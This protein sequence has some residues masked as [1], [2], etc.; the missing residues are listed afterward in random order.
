MVTAP[1]AWSRRAWD[2]TS[3]RRQPL[4]LWLLGLV[5]V[6]SLLARVAWLGEPCRSPCRSAD[7][8]VL[9]FDEAYYVNAARVID[10]IRP[11]AGQHYADAPLH[12][13]PNAEH[14]QLAKLI[15]AGTI[16]LFGDGP[17]GWRAGSVAFGMLALLG[18]FAVVLAAGGGPWLALATTAVMATDNLA[19]VHSRI[20]TL[21]VYVLAPMLL[22]TAAYLRGRPWLAGALA[23]LAVSMKEV[24]VFVL[25][26][27]SLF[28]L[29]R[30][31]R[32]DGDRPRR[33][34]PL[35]AARARLLATWCTAGV[36]LIA[37]VWAMDV[38]V[39]AYDPGSGHRYAGDPISHLAH[40]V[41]FSAKLHAPKGPQGIASAPLHWLVDQTA[42]PYARTVATVATGLHVLA[43]HTLLDFRGEINPAIIFLAVP[44]LAYGALG[45]KRSRNDLQLAGLAWFLGCFLP[46]GV[47]SYALHRIT[48]LFYMLI[49]MPGLYLLATAMFAE[50]R[51]AVPFGWIAIALW[52]PALLYGLVH[53]YPIRS[54]MP[55]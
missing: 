23:G 48:Y 10:G 15:T 30:A 19:L 26:A 9:V 7:D 46:F 21:D 12:T 28:E 11:A 50:L 16:E 1:Q 41:S 22:A 38:L 31:W 43:R 35:R 2:A 5:V 8:H 18:M 17:W 25:A 52:V 34:L 13:D 3:A 36:T 47:E 29:L 44:A 51:S 6:V 37:C 49:A 55:F 4:A 42:I 32:G 20:A 14:P 54:H 33:A 39:P 40:M 27:I 45:L 53:L 24:G